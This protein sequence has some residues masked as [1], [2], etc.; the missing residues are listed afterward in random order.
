MN[1]YKIKLEDKAAFINRLD[2]LGVEVD[3]YNIVDNKLKGYFEF[4]TDNPITDNIVKTILKQSE[5]INTIKEMEKK[6]ITKSQLAE[7]I[8]EEMAKMKGEKKAPKKPMKEYLAGQ[9]ATIEFGEWVIQNYPTIAQALGETAYQIG[10]NA[11]GIATVGSL[12]LTGGIGALISKVRSAMKKA[13]GGVSSMAEAD[14]EEA[15]LIDIFSG[16]M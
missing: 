2:K 6:K 11:V 12:A 8:R 16:G 14:S 15:E 4:T 13:K 1:D 7:I 5:K 9:E 10:S 3:S